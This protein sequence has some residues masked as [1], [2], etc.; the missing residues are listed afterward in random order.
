MGL[1]TCADGRFRQC[2]WELETARALL[3]TAPLSDLR[4]LDWG[5]GITVQLARLWVTEGRG[6][7]AERILR[8]TAMAHP[9]LVTFLIPTP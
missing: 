6:A 8:E 7:D 4:K 3:P 5:L 9:N 1:V 2:E